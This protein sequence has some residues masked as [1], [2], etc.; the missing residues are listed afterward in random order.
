MQHLLDDPNLRI[1]L[2]AA[3]CIL[4]TTLRTPKQRPYLPK[5]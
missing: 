3:S 1:R 2:I 4:Q 5:P